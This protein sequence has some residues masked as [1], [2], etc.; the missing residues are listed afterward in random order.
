MRRG[1]GLGSSASG[2]LILSA[3]A[4]LALAPASAQE[5]EDVY[6][7]TAEIPAPEAGGRDDVGRDE[8][9]RI[10]GALADPF[11]LVESMPGVLA[12]RSGLAYVYVRGA[13]PS[14]TQYIYD[15]IPIPLLSHLA[16]GQSAIH[17]GATR[18][19]RFFPGA[20]PARF[21]RTI[22]GAHAMVA[23]RYGYPGPIVS[24][25]TP[26]LTLQYGDY[27]ARGRVA[28]S[29]SDRVE[30]VALGSVDALDNPPYAD[31]STDRGDM[32][33]TFHRV[34]MRLVRALAHTEIGLDGS[35]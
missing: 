18:E 1:R 2:A 12:L 22:G 30:L 7:A 27:L 33:L 3:V 14:G 8:V 10:P 4:V 29:A 15:G 26:G 6:D 16:V 19:V 24:A 31:S 25:L 13:P 21:G 17:P 34:E 28:L 5:E 9:E 35:L 11:R 20:A 23:A 32:F